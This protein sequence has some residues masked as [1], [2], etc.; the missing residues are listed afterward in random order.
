MYTGIVQAML[1]IAS[2][3]KLP[4]LS[5]FS[6]VLPESMMAELETG[7]SIAVN[8]TCFTVT[9]IDGTEVFFDAIQETLALSNLKAIEVGTQVN[10][11]RS[12][13]ANAEVG[14]HVLS[15]HIVGTAAVVS[16][17]TTENNQRLTFRGDPEWTKYVFS[18][19]YLALNGAS[20]TI[21]AVVGDEFAVNLIPET[22]RRTNFAL[23]REGDPVN[24]EIEQQ[25]QVIV[26]TVER[27]LAERL[28]SASGD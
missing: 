11:E 20:L 8:G 25:T 2:L 19:G 6:L 4:G 22:L 13:R 21:A 1:P 18:K 10:V 17:E 7:A 14:G 26:D 16:I 27:V 24:V 15:G 9:V 3:K 12:A 23:L 28:S 5:T